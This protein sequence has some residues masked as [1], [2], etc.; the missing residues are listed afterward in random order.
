M[1]HVQGFSISSSWNVDTL[2]LITKMHHLPSHKVYSFIKLLEIVKR[3]LQK[4]NTCVYTS[5]HVR[6]RVR[7]HVRACDY[8]SDHNWTPQHYFQS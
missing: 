3:L 8:P 7:T 6:V 5:V 1:H 4:Q 2:K